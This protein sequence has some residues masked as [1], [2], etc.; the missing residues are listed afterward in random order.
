MQLCCMC[1]RYKVVSPI[2]DNLA[3]V[4]PCTNGLLTFNA[5]IV[6]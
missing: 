2:E 1:R 4:I 5:S 3:Y 6:H